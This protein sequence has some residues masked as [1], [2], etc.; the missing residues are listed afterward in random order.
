MRKVRAD[1]IDKTQIMLKCFVSFIL[2]EHEFKVVFE[3]VSVEI[4][5]VK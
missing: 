5:F 2:A 1:V 4:A 3:F